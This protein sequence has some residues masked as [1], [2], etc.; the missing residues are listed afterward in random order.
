MYI[1]IGLVGFI[2]IGLAIYY[3]IEEVKKD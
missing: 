1:L 3:F 2:A